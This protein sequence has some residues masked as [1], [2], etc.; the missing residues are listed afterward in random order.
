MVSAVV[1]GA[2]AN[3]KFHVL[4]VIAFFFIHDISQKF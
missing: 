4:A 1:L 3:I 2:K